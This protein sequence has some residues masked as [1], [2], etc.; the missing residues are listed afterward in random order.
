MPEPRCIERVSVQLRRLDVLVLGGN[1]IGDDCEVLAI[2]HAD[3]GLREDRA[4]DFVDRAAG[5]DRIETHCAENVP[6]RGFASVVV[7][8]YAKWAVSVPYAHDLAHAELGLPRLPGE[9][10][11]I[12]DVEAWLVPLRILPDQSGCIGE[13]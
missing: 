12:W 9:V 10:V 6:R 13:L 1:V 11:Q 4:A 8:G 5:A 2:A 3:D 7:S